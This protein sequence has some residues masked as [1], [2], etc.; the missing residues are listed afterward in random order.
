VPLGFVVTGVTVCYG[1]GAALSFVSGA[2]LFQFALP[3]T[4]TTQPLNDALG[5]PASPAALCVDS[6]TAVSVDP[7]AGGPVYLLLPLSFNAAEAVT[8]HGVG[9]QLAPISAP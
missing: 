9:L 6:A 8:I 2:Q 7:S 1:P 3:P 5:A 4:A